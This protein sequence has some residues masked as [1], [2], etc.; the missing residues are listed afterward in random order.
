MKR[1]I[2]FLLILFFQVIQAKES[3][4]YHNYMWA[5]FND[6]Q[7]K[8]AVAQKH[9]SKLFDDGAP[10]HAYK[11]YLHHLAS[12]NQWTLIVRLMP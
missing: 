1:T 7:G 4:F 12:T 11:A 3:H 9:Y 8:P 10:A 6:L 5:H 2:A